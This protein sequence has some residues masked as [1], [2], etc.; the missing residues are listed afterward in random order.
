MLHD[1]IVKEFP[2]D[3]ETPSPIKHRTLTG[4]TI[5]KSYLL[6]EVIKVLMN[7]A[8]FANE[9]LIFKKYKNDLAIEECEA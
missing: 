6:H 1:I 5:L 9:R 8:D 7:S 2:V 3:R 4:R